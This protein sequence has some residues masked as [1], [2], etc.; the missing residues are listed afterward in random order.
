MIVDIY[1]VMKGIENIRPDHTCIVIDVLRASTSIICLMER[2]LEKLRVVANV[3]DAL[4][5]KDMRYIL[6]GERGEKPL[7]GFKYDNSPYIIS[8][9][10]W[11]GK[12]VVLTTT[13][14]TRALI[15][16]QACKNVA[17]AG[18]RNI[19]AVANYAIKINNPV[20]IIPIGNMG[21]PRIEDEICADALVNRI[22][23]ISVD[24]SSKIQPI[25][26]DRNVKTSAK[27]KVYWKDVELALTVNTTSIV[28]T[29][30]HEYNLKKKAIYILT[31]YSG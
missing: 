19:D 11:S 17:V 31:H 1:S 18:F 28:P 26:K 16:V 10:D 29:L 24:W 30:V 7:K 6:I 12:R 13:N 3:E 4:S 9:L 5:L 21:E 2:G 20:A 8:Q 22:Q 25:W 27:G 15:A 14:G 23:G